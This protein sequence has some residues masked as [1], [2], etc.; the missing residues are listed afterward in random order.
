MLGPKVILTLS[1]LTSVPD[2]VGGFTDTWTS[3]RDIEGCLMTPSGN[4]NVIHRKVETQSTHV[5]YC[6]YDLG[7]DIT[8][9]DR[10]LF[11][12][13]LFEINYIQNPA[14]LNIHLQIHLKEDV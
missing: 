12:T 13:R 7:S 3:V 9:R 8:Q 1:Q 2:G 10:L 4:E 5:F 14:E 6:D 11:G